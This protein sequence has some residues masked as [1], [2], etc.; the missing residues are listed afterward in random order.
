MSVAVEQALAMS[1]DEPG[2]PNAFGVD[3]KPTQLA[4][5]VPCYNEQEVLPETCSRMTALLERMRRAG[6]ISAG[7]RI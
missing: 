7:S 5:V 3:A 6:R 2:V 1:A 4:I